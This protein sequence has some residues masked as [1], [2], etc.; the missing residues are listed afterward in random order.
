MEEIA[1]YVMEMES[2]GVARGKR[3]NL[4]IC[5]KER[6]GKPPPFFWG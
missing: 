3:K 5:F 2:A 6:G 4:F 1:R